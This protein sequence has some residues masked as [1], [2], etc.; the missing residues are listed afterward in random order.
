MFNYI[1]WVY[2]IAPILLCVFESSA[3]AQ[4]TLTLQEALIIAR[5]NNKNIVNAQKDVETAKAR[6]IVARSYAN[7]EVDYDLFG[8]ETLSDYELNVVQEIEIAGKRKSRRLIAEDEIAIANEE[9]N[10]IWS[11][12]A[13]ETKAAYYNI[14]LLEKKK[15]LAQENLNLF[16]KLSD[17]VQIRYNSGEVLISEVNRAKIELSNSE[18]ELFFSE[19][20]LRAAIAQFNLILNKP[21]NYEFTLEDSLVYAE[22]SINYEDLASKALAGYPELKIKAMTIQKNSREIN[23]ARQGIFSNP[24]IGFVNKKEEGVFLS[25]ASIGISLPLW[26]RNKGEIQQANI[27]LEKAKQDIEFL[28]KKL[29]V[30]VYEANVEVEYASKKV[31]NF[32]KSIE[33]SNSIITQVDMQYKEGKTDFLEYLD[34]LRTIKEV[35]TGYYEAVVDYNKKLALIEKL[36]NSEL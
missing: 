23:F 3:I 6:L 13:F 18:N 4:D 1:R 15:A 34:S 26:Y 32:K 30:A 20:E 28:K 36:I 21:A 27:E 2:Q 31:T 14:L 5:D 8:H 17:S 24:K 10:Y 12:V 16:R 35:K 22:K 29:L 11:E 19:K 25:G 7:P 33:Q 9:F